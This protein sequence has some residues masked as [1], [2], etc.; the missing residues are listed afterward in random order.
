MM[1]FNAGQFSVQC[2]GELQIREVHIGQ[3]KPKKTK[4]GIQ[5]RLRGWQDL[6]E[7]PRV[8]VNR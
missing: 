5:T 2:V 7:G 4:S 6:K 8:L 1:K 3:H